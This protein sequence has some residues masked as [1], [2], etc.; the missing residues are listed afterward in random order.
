MVRNRLTPSNKKTQHHHFSK[1]EYILPHKIITYLNHQTTNTIVSNFIPK[2][3]SHPPPPPPS[4][5]ATHYHTR[6]QSHCQSQKMMLVPLWVWCHDLNV[7]SFIIC[8]F[9]QSRF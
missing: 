3:K 8:G 6:C 5:K 7:C 2:R 4:I 1:V 9:F